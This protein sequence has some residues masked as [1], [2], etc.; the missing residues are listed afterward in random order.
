MSDAKL[1]HIT[2]ATLSGSH[3]DPF[4]IAQKLQDVIDKAFISLDIKITPGE[5]WQLRYNDRVLDLQ[6]TIEENKIPDGATLH[7]APL[8]NGGGC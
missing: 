4:D 3:T 1:I 8:E 5:E 2:V 6:A 7:L